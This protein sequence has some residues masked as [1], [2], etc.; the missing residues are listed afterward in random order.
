MSKEH[1]WKIPNKSVT[2]RMSIGSD[3]VGAPAH[4]QQHQAGHAIPMPPAAGEPASMQPHTAHPP[5]ATHAPPPAASHAP[6][7]PAPAK[8]NEE[9]IRVKILGTIWG[10]A[11]GMLGICIPLAAV[12]GEAVGGAAAVLPLG[13]VAGATVATVSVLNHFKG[14]ASSASTKSDIQQAA[15]LHELEERL[16]NLET[17][18]NFERRLA[19]EAI[20]KGNQSV[21]TAPMP[22]DTMTPA[23][24][25]YQFAEPEASRAAH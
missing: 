21:S 5:Q 8:S 6:A 3:D 13:V 19:E 25:T 9:D 10:C 14:S 24:T 7:Q 18:N 23:E 11:T 16:A 17:I 22:R 4:P 1:S 2:L 12:V 20:A 15:R